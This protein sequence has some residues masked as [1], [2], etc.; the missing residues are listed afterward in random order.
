[1]SLEPEL[2][3]AIERLTALGYTVVPPASAAIPDAAAGQRWAAPSQKVRPRTVIRLGAH[4]F[5]PSLGDVCVFFRYD[6]ETEADRL[7]VLNPKAWDAWV[8][9]NNARPV[10]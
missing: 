6:E 2:Q 4:H 5:W 3:S 10:A 1:M 8:K 7:H 9:K